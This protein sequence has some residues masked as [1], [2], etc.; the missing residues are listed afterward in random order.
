MVVGR[1]RLGIPSGRLRRTNCCNPVLRERT[2][3]LVMC[4]W[5][6]EQIVFPFFLTHYK[7]CVCSTC[8]RRGLAGVGSFLKGVVGVVGRR[9]ELGNTESELRS[10][11]RY[12]VC[13]YPFFS[14]FLSTR[15]L[16]SPFIRPIRLRILLSSCQ[17]VLKF[18]EVPSHPAAADD[19]YIQIR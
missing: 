14:S 1:C 4:C 9:S 3:W 5:V 15:L 17:I 7:G 18:Q 11:K 2:G 13:G 16:D 19:K 6:A 8:E 12:E 10:G